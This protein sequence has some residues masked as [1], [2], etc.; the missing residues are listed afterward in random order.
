MMKAGFLPGGMAMQHCEFCGSELPINA[1]FCGH[2]GRTPGGTTGR[3]T[4]VSDSPT[5]NLPPLNAPTA[6]GGQSQS[7]PGNEEQ[8]EEEERRRRAILLDLP[9]PAV[10]AGEGQL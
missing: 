5:A 7:A 4:D 10:L 6:L 9:F 2:C 3:Q 8:E 1:R